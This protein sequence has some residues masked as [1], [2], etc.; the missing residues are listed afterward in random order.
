VFHGI[1]ASVEAVFGSGDLEG[2]TV[3]VQGA[4]GVGGELALLLADAGAAVLV[5]DIDAA[6]ARS[7]AAARSRAEAIAVDGLLDVACDVYAPCAVGGVLTE[8]SAARLR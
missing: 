8:E 3:L 1:R 6:R 7:V 5:A 2:R 4:G